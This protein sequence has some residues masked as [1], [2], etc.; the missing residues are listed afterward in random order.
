MLV[1]GLAQAE[2][3]YKSSNYGVDEVF[4]GAGGLNDASSASYRARASLG[5]LTVGNSSSAN[6][7]TYNG[8]TTT[9]EPFIEFYVSNTNVN[10]G[11]LTAGTPK[12]TTA[13]FN[14]RTYL[15]SGYVI[16]SNS[17]PPQNNSYTMQNLSSQTA[18]ITNTEQFGINLA[19]NNIAG[20]GDFGA[21][22]VQVPTG[23][24]SFGYATDTYNDS[25]LFKYVAGDVIARSDSSSG[26][27][28]YTI[29]YL[30]NI[31][32]ITP[33]GEFVF[34]HDLVATSYY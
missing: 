19:A 16:V 5:D 22:P 25:N 8:F 21:V 17:E 10:L 30:F 26:E 23:T 29:S 13:T 28:D 14:I 9:E 11:L 27:T 24:Y 32:P 4:M 12:V 1:I 7:Q 18:S 20:I 31:S 33:G 3:T 2:P 15:A 6:F 34:I